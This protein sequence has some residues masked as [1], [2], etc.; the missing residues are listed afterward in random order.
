MLM[1]PLCFITLSLFVLSDLCSRSQ[2]LHKPIFCNSII[3]IISH[4]ISCDFWAKVP[5][6]RYCCNNTQCTSLLH[7][8]FFLSIFP[9]HP[10]RSIIKSSRCHQGPQDHQQQSSWGREG[11]CPG[12]QRD[13]S[14]RGQWRDWPGRGRAAL[15]RHVQGLPGLQPRRGM[16]NND[17]RAPYIFLRLYVFWVFFPP[18]IF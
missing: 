9:A 5:T 11:H 3:L 18:P 16:M 2:D 15:W 6:V 14:V 17:Q 4:V 13:S 12:A 10:W 1:L 7:G 8:C